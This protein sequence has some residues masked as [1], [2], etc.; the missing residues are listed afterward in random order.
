MKKKILLTLLAS[1]VFW[2]SFYLGDRFL[3]REIANWYEVPLFVTLFCANSVSLA[4]CVK[5]WFLDIR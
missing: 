3:T 4:V 1:V 5:Q 2:L